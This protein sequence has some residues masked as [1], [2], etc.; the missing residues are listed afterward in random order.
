MSETIIHCLKESVSRY[1]DSEAVV[2]KDQ[3]ITYKQLWS[4]VCSVVS[5]L[6]GQGMKKG[7]RVGLLI[8]NSPEYIAVY[9]GA[10]SAGGVVVGLNT[11][12]KAS[13]L[14]NW[15]EHCDARFLF[16]SINHPEFNEIT[17]N[18]TYQLN[19]IGIGEYLN[20]QKSTCDLWSEIV[21]KSLLE[22]DMTMLADMM[23]PATI[24]YTS[25]T[26]GSP[27]GVTLS[28]R[29]LISNTR[30]IIEYLGLS[31]KDSIVSV[32]P[33]YYSYGNSVMHT[34]LA[35]GGRLV[36]E[37][38]FVYPHKV[39]EKIV[40]ERVTGFSGVPSLYSLLLS[41]TKL[42]EYDFS[43]VRYM[44]QAGGAMAPA[45]IIRLLEEIP[46]VN[47]YV[48]YGQTEGTARLSYL[49]PKNLI[50]KMGS[51]GKAIPGVT[52]EI[53]DENNNICPPGV[54]GEICANGDNIMIGYWNSPDETRKVIVDS[55][56]KTGDL[57][58]YDEDG[59]LYIDGRSSDMIKT[60][61][62]RI[63]PKEIEEVIA[64]LVE[65]EEVAVVGVPDEILGQVIKAVIVPTSKNALEKKTVQAHCRKNLSL[66]KIPKIIEF[67]NELPKTSSGKV[68]RYLLQNNN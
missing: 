23:S 17:K 3:R 16:S 57:A 36:L 42:K 25:G 64:H 38:S 46:T 66:Y 39:L 27:K 49:P 45:S 60:G 43:K 56:L 14:I 52:L 67:T 33:F 34:H 30:S 20:D 47:F 11:T 55:W 8:E 48:M 9:Y 62:N 15:L 21:D 7:D 4:M 1:P 59:F 51:I 12:A 65:V 6:H 58:H 40:Q 63:S 13:D 22:L 31:S 29:N 28:H 24:I 10:L 19:V 37:N 32:L 35:V 26:T 5:Y 61:A 50:E 68:K 54:T 44:T 2:Y 53:H 41:R 18:C